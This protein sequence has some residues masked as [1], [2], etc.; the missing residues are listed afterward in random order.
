MEQSLSLV[1][2]KF[3]VSI[4]YISIA[5]LLSLS[6]CVDVPNSCSIVLSAVPTPTVTTIFDPTR[7]PYYTGQRLEISC[8]TGDFGRVYPGAT[9]DIS[10]MGPNGEVVS[11]SRI[12]VGDVS[13]VLPDT[14]FLRLFTFST[15]SMTDDDGSYTCMGTIRPVDPSIQQYVTNGVTTADPS[16]LTVVGMF[17]C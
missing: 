14:V 13:A 8:L 4:L 11:D 17:I 15:L 5:V 12:T 6:V 2:L 10:L 16:T 7:G 9:A 3:I 1:S